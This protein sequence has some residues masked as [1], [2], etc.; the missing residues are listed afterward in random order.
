M[1]EPTLVD[2]FGANATQNATDLVI[3]KADLAALGLTA[4]AANTAESLLISIIL[5][6]AAV[7]TEVNR[8]TD[9]TNR[10]IAIEFAGADIFSDGLGNDFLRRAWSV[11]AYTDYALPDFDPDDV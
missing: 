8:L 1:A 6:A 9:T 11:S 10:N 3:K 5:K 2:V 4:S 7:L